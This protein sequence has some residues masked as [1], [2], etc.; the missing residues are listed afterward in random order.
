VE[1][2]LLNL[3]ELG[4]GEILEDERLPEASTLPS[5]LNARSPASSSTQ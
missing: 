1:K 3:V 2:L 5:T 4:P